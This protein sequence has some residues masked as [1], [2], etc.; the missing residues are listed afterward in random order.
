VPE[1]T[2]LERPPCLAWLKS[3]VTCPQNHQGKQRRHLPSSFPQRRCMHGKTGNCGKHSR[4]AFNH[5]YL[6]RHMRGPSSCCSDSMLH[7]SDLRVLAVCDH[8]QGKLSRHCRGGHRRLHCSA[9]CRDRARQH[10][11]FVLSLRPGPA[12][13]ESCDTFPRS[14]LDRHAIARSPQRCPDQHWLIAVWQVRPHH[15]CH[16]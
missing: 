6:I 12:W 7:G 13:H 3:A 15:A 16:Y 4:C 11:R 1:P 8:P 9:D 10:A 2:T 14:V 5:R